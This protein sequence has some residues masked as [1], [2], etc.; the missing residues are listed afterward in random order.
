MQKGKAAAKG[1]HG[2]NLAPGHAGVLSCPR[3][4]IGLALQ[5]PQPGG[6]TMVWHM[7]CPEPTSLSEGGHG[8]SCTQTARASLPLP[9]PHSRQRACLLLSSSPVLKNGHPPCR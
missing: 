1:Q 4:P 6:Q 7:A 5:L 3:E 9:G 2:A 8:D